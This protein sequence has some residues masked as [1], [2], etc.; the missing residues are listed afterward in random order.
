[1]IKLYS[2]VGCPRC[3]FLKMQLDALGL[4]YEYTI[5]VEEVRKLGFQTT[6]LLKVDDKVM[7]FPDAVNWLK[8]VG[9]K[10]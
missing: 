5:D 6:P 9:V 7:M 1:M 10:N 8:S 4:D 2:N 3:D